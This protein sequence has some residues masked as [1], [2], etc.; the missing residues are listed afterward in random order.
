MCAWTNFLPYQRDL[1]PEFPMKIHLL[2][3]TKNLEK[4]L[5]PQ[6]VNTLKLCDS[7]PQAAM[8][9]TC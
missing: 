7:I 3:A 2:I 9:T 6:N 5:T 8:P 1:Q 4:L